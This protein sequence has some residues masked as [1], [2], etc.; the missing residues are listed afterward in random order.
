MKYSIQFSH[1]IKCWLLAGHVLG[2]VGLSHVNTNGGMTEK[3]HDDIVSD[4]VCI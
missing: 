1:G 2:I 4:V 3:N